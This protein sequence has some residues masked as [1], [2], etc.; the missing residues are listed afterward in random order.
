MES[1]H[2]VSCCLAGAG[3]T[4][5]LTVEV[6]VLCGGHWD[7]WNIQSTRE[8]PEQWGALTRELEEVIYDLFC[9]IH[10][11][12][13]GGSCLYQV[14]PDGRLK[15]RG[16]RSICKTGLLPKGPVEQG[17]TS[18]AVSIILI[19]WWATDIVPATGDFTLMPLSPLFKCWQT[20]LR[21]WPVEIA[22]SWPFLQGL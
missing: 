12:S 22:V 13:G 6:Q 3:G 20:L 19:L 8:G 11:G 14:L 18:M 10:S 5:G 4:Q 15:S 17:G 2:L 21:C 16:Q 9:E 1:D 7:V